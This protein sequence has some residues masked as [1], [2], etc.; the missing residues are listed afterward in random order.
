MK[1]SAAQLMFVPL[2]ALIVACQGDPPAESTAT[3]EIEPTNAATLTP[4]PETA[5]EA[6]DPT[7]A[8][9]IQTL[10]EQTQVP[11]PTV[12]VRETVSAENFW[13]APFV[14][15]FG[16]KFI[17]SQA[18]PNQ[19]ISI[20]F[21]EPMDKDS[22]MEALTISPAPDAPFELEWGPNDREVALNFAEPL[23][24]NAQYVIRVEKTAVNKRGIPMIGYYA[25]RFEPTYNQ[26]ISQ[27][28]PRLEELNSVVSRA[29]SISNSNLPGEPVVIEFAV[30]VDQQSAEEAFFIEPTVR[31][32]FSWD[33]NQMIF[34][35]N[36]EEMGFSAAYQ[37]GLTPQLKAP[38]GTPLEGTRLLEQTY[39]WSF[40]YGTWYGDS[41]GLPLTFGFGP[42]IQAVDA[43]GRRAIEF[44][45]YSRFPQQINASLYPLT[46]DEFNVAWASHIPDQKYD[47]DR[48]AI[49]LDVSPAHEW[50]FETLSRGDEK[51]PF[52]EVIIPADVP[53]GIYILEISDGFAA[54]AIFVTLSANRL[55]VKGSYGEI[56]GQLTSTAGEPVAD[57]VIN[58][59]SRNGDNL[60]QIATAQ[61]G[62]FRLPLPE[63]VDW[64]NQD[65]L[66][67]VVARAE[68]DVVTARFEQPSLYRKYEDGYLDHNEW[69]SFYPI[70]NEWRVFS[71]TD[72]PVY[73]PGQFVNFKAMLR[74]DD[75]NLFGTPPVGTPVKV[76]LLGGVSTQTRDLETN[77]FGTV[78]DFFPLPET[79]NLGP[80]GEPDIFVLQFE[81]DGEVFEHPV[82]IQP[83]PEPP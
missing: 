8:P 71:Q 53:V 12:P 22:V 37:F 57:A 45:T 28:Q 42:N 17:T 6:A 77:A 76:T 25:H 21:S 83:S 40:T 48:V 27:E 73:R 70:T 80:R 74:T 15:L 69:S 58:L 49:P 36:A 59:H 24:P 23:D 41:I 67:Y 18:D 33:G 63:A 79:I 68:D 39:A 47:Q 38:D 20:T 1:K 35:P 31:G 14:R 66:N 3:P 62:T 4:T 64:A 46:V 78:S 50:Q 34:Q 13:P 54:D 75:D 26:R 2:L 55:I 7:L 32:S 5:V 60:G 51:F 72:F 30:L 56:T 61:A 16:Y 11:V 9:T 29:Y 10:V 81:V 52:T 43:N 82:P 44:Y 65:R 19:A